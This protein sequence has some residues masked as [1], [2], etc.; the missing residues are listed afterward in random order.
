MQGLYLHDIEEWCTEHG[1]VAVTQ[2]WK[3]QDNPALTHT[4]QLRY[5][6]DAENVPVPEPI[7]VACL[8]V[9]GTWEECVLW[10]TETGVFASVEDWP[11]YYALRGEDDERNALWEKPGHRFTW[12][13]RER[14]GRYL[15]V[16]VHNLWDAVILPATRGQPEAL[17]LMTSHHE[18]VDLWSS[19]PKRFPKPAVPDGT[20]PCD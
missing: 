3:I 16:V 9:L 11:A 18:C 7:R 14:L 2:D 5:P 17:R 20:G 19:T 15:E 13:E 6:L 4:D 8:E 12:E 10:I 1:V